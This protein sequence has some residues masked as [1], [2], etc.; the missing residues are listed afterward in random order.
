MYQQLLLSTLTPLTVIILT[1]HNTVNILLHT[2][3]NIT[4]G[5]YNYFNSNNTV[6]IQVHTII[7]IT[8]GN[9]NN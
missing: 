7:N 1:R 3:I 4:T 2:V 8:T 9:Y 5:T 6:N